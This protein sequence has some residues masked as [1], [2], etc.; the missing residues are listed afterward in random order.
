MRAEAFAKVNLDL[1]V[2]A[3][4]ATGLHPV[5]SLMQSIDWHDTIAIEAAEDDVF[6]VDGPDEIR[7]RSTNLAW[8]ALQA[9]VSA[10]GAARPFAVHLEKRIPV[11]AG[12]GGGSADAAASLVLATRLLGASDEVRD[13]LA[14]DL[15]ADVPF[16]LAGG[17]AWVTDHGEQVESLPSFDDFAIA[18]VVPPFPLCTAAVYRRWD[19][20]GGP[21]RAGVAGRDL[22]MSLRDQ[23][24]LGNDL[25]AAAIDL[26]P[27]LGD[28]MAD[29]ASAWGQPALMSGSGPAIFGFFA[30]K[31]AAAEAAAAIGGARSVRGCRPITVGW[32]LE[33]GG[34]LPA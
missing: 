5:R 9:V 6:E 34:T 10:V 21:S 31:S 15:G 4:D 28:W 32:R 29:A 26:E 24:P 16:C 25:T 20:L 13:A 19:D 22:P 7:E 12:L 18:V 3:R 27:A 8:R 14:P 17:T 1:R 33:A 11:A 23:A 30:D 2:R